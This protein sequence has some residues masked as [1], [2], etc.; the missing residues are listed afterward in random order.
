MTDDQIA[1]VFGWPATNL[2]RDSSLM[3]RLRVVAGEAEALAHVA[4]AERIARQAAQIER[5]RSALTAAREI[6]AM[7]IDSY[8]EAARALG[9]KLDDNDVEYLVGMDAVLRQIDEAMGETH[10]P[11]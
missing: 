8:E 7:D 4:C 5:M 3:H 1:A 11:R 6:F 10:D 2:R 9:E